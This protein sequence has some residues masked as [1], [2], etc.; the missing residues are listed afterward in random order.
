MIF[1]SVAVSL[2]AL[3]TQL[4]VLRP[5]LGPQVYAIAAVAL[6]PCEHGA[7]HGNNRAD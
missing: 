7:A 3:E 1:N 2:I 5:V 6:P 4:H